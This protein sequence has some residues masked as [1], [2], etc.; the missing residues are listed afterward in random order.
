MPN[1][2]NTEFRNANEVID[3]VDLRTQ[4]QLTYWS[5]FHIIP[6]ELLDLLPFGEPLGPTRFYSIVDY[7]FPN[8]ISAV[9]QTFRTWIDLDIRQYDGT[10]ARELSLFYDDTFLWHY[11]APSYREEI[12]AQIQA[13]NRIRFLSR[14]LLSQTQI[15]LEFNEIR[16]QDLGNEVFSF[17]YTDSKEYSYSFLTQVWETCILNLDFHLI[18]PDQ[19]TLPITVPNTSGRDTEYQERLDILRSRPNNLELQTNYWD[20]I[21]STAVGDSRASTP[22]SEY[23]RSR[24][25]PTPFQPASPPV[26]DISIVCAC[27]I[28]VCFCDI[29]QPGTPPTPLGINLWN[30]RFYPRPLDRVHYNRQTGVPL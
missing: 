24:A 10:P 5:D 4:V 28:D 9:N 26:P 23:L 13:G 7:Q 16:L 20:S 14:F 8:F 25:L 18:N 6:K 17:V 22:I 1:F 19:Y 15:E 21:A 2:R 3:L 11:S 12:T 27:G 29:R 30:P